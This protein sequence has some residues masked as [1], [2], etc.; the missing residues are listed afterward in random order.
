MYREC[1]QYSDDD[2]TQRAH[3]VTGVFE[4]AGHGQN[5]RAQTGL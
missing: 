2:R 5:S 4:R 1:T 3:H